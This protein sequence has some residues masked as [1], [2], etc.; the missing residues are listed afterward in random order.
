MQFKVKLCNENFDLCRG[1]GSTDVYCKDC[2]QQ[3]PSP[4]Y[5]EKDS[6]QIPDWLHKDSIDWVRLKAIKD[7]VKLKGSDSSNTIS[8]DDE[9][10][11]KAYGNLTTVPTNP[12]GNCQYEAISLA[13]LGADTIIDTCVG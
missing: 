3:N 5:Y 6:D 12:N 1:G 4:G 11:I 9:Q 13:L 8:N 7:E 10:W 2:V